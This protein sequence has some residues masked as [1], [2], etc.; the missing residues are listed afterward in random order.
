MVRCTYG[1]PGTIINT[2][3]MWETL[4]N[5]YIIT[6][7]KVT[8]IHLVCLV[9]PLFVLTNISEQIFLTF[10]WTE[11]KWLHNW[12]CASGIIELYC[13]SLFLIFQKTNFQFAD[14]LWIWMC[15]IYLKFSS[16]FSPFR[17]RFR[18]C[19]WPRN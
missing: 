13:V 18:L 10:Y 4:Q 12:T 3:V 11:F 14:N 2:N 6:I 19:Y 8:L 9:V 16:P 15:K 7:E 17:H 5:H 1:H